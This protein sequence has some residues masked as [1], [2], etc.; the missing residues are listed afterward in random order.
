MPSV[1][2]VIPA[3]NEEKTIERCV[4]SCFAQTKPAL[5]IIVVNNKSTDATTNVV[6]RLQREFAGAK[7]ELRLLQQNRTQGITPTRNHGMKAAHGDVIGRIDADSMLD[8]GWVA[9]VEA[10]FGDASVAAASGPVVYHDM[11]AKNFGFRADN[12]A[13][14]LY[15]KLAKTHRWLFG[16]NMAV[17][18]SVW[19]QIAPELCLDEADLMHE[20]IDAALHLH[21]AGFR[22]VYLPEMIGGMSARR[23]EDSPK[24][25][26]DYV[27]RYE[28]TYQHHDVSSRSARIPI[29]IYLST[30][31]PL[32]FIRFAYN[33]E[34]RPF[35]F[36]G[37]RE[38]IGQHGGDS[39]D[40]EIVI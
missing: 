21:A 2:I 24:D 38:R 32:K 20:D 29:F 4:R 19:R 16:S 6:R 34:E 40:D 10:G 9:A 33:A 26:Y 31:F 17:R 8:P 5:E 15:D 18:A 13:R 12:S 23:L 1:S 11:P 7:T 25:F 14:T 3:Y 22:V 35:S 30:Y 39:R 37:F 36:E 28:R 27:M